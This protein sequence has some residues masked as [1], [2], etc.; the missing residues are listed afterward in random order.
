MFFKAVVQ[1]VLLYGSETWALT[2]SALRCLEGF[3][4][5][6][7]C[8]MARK[9]GP[10]KNDQAGEWTHSDMKELF[11][12]VVLYSLTEYIEKRRKTIETYIRDRPILHLC[13]S[14]ER[15]R[16]P[17]NAGGDGSSRMRRTRRGKRMPLL[18]YLSTRLRR[19]R[20][21]LLSIV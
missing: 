19:T 6:A 17:S 3:F 16:V 5:R 18:L 7:A 20:C 4:Y 14:G 12:E 15:L 2:E 1:T 21:C 8:N 11:K 10:K 9:N 13:R